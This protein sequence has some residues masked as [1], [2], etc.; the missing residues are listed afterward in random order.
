MS[1]RGRWTPI[2]EPNPLDHFRADLQRVQGLMLYLVKDCC[3]ERAELCRP[4]ADALL[5]CRAA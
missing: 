2:G 3:G 4:L 5:A 1:E